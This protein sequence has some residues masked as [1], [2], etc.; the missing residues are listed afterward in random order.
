MSSISSETI[1]TYAFFETNEI[2]EK[3]RID[4][5]NEKISAKLRIK[6]TQHKEASLNSLLRGETTRVVETKYIWKIT[7][8]EIV[9]NILDLA[10][11]EID[12][13]DHIITPNDYEFISCVGIH[14]EELPYYQ[15][16][17]FVKIRDVRDFH[18]LFF[19]RQLSEP[20]RIWQENIRSIAKG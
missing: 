12:N 2:F 17:F 16:I 6:P 9:Q 14:C 1:S 15:V 19:T 10:N 20:Y 5:I 11:F 8:P 3:D 13:V 7:S 18:A 4:E